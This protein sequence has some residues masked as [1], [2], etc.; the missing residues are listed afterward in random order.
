MKNKFIFLYSILA[1]LSFLVIVSGAPQIGISWISPTAD[2]YVNQSLFFNVTVNVS[3]H[4]E[5][6]DLINVSLDPIAS[7]TYNFTTCGATGRFGPTSANCTANYTGTTLAGLVTLANTSSINGTQN[8]TVPTSGTYSLEAWGAGGGNGTGTGGLGGYGAYIY[9]EFSLTAGTVL[10]I[11]V[12]QKGITDA[13]YGGGGGGASFV[14]DKTNNN[15]LVVAGG[16]GGGSIRAATY[17]RGRNASLTTT[18]INGSLDDTLEYNLGGINQNGGN[19]SSNSG[20]GGGGYLGNGT[21]VAV[22]SKGGTSYI[23]GGAGGST[24]STGSYGGFGGGGSGYGGGGGGGGYSGGGGGGYSSNGGGGG[25]GASYNNGT[26]QN[27]SAGAN[28][29]F[30]KVTISLLVSGKGGLVSNTTGATPFYTNGSNPYPVNLSNGSSQIITWWV[31]ASG[32]TL[33]SNYTFFVYANKTSNLTIGNKTS[34]INISIADITLPIINMTYPL[35]ISYQEELSIINYTYIDYTGGGSCWYTNNSGLTNS[36]TTSAGNNFSSVSISSGS[37]TFRVYCND[38]SNNINYS[39]VTFVENIPQI[40][41]SRVY[42]TNSINVPYGNFFNITVNVSCSV[43]DCDLINVSLDPKQEEIDLEIAGDIQ[44]ASAITLYDNK[45]FEYDIADGCS[46]ADGMAD[47]FDTGMALSVNTTAFSGIR[48]TTEDSGREAICTAQNISSMNVSRKV[49]VPNNLNWSRFLEI[50]HNP[51]AGTVCVDVKIA[52]N[53][54]SDGAD[55]LNTSDG[56]VT[57]ELSDNWMMWDDTS[58]TSGDDA[59]G[60]I[61]HQGT[62]SVVNISGLSPATASGGAKYFNWSNICVTAGST[63]ILMHFFTQMDTRRQSE[64]ESASIYSTFSDS[65]HTSGMSSNEVSQVVNWQLG[66]GGLVSNT[67][68]ATPFYT[69]GSNPYPVNLSAGSSQIITWWVNATGGAGNYTYFVYANKTSN[70]NISAITTQW[71]VSIDVNSSSS[72]STDTTYPVF[73]NFGDNNSTLFGQGIGKFNVSINTTNGTVLLEINGTNITARNLVSNVYNASYNFTLNGTYTYRWISWGNG[74]SRLMDSSTVQVFTVNA[75]DIVKPA[76]KFGSANT[77]SGNFSQSTITAQI[78]ASDTNLQRVVVYLY[79]S[80]G[81]ISSNT[82]NGSVSITY[83]SLA[84]GTYYLNASANDTYANINWTETRVIVLDRTPPNVSLVNPVNGFNSTNTLQN[85]SFNATDAY[86]TNCS[87]YMDSPTS[88]GNTLINSNL[89]TKNG[90]HTNLSASDLNNRTYLW[91]VNCSDAASNTNI[92]VYRNITIDRIAPNMTITSPKQN[93]VIGYNLYIYTDIVDSLSGVQSAKFSILNYSNVSQIIFNGSLNSSGNW[94]AIWNTSILGEIQ[95]NLTLKFDANDTLGNSY[96]TNYTIALD[97]VNPTIQIIVPDTSLKYYNSNFNITSIIQ[98]SNL[99]YSNYSLNGS[100]QSGIVHLSGSNYTWN[101]VIDIVSTSEGLNNISFYARDSAGN[102][103]TLSSIFGVDYTAPSITL[104]SPSAS[105]RT[106]ETDITFNW[107]VTDSVYSTLTCNM[108]VNSLIR[109]RDLSC[110]SG[111]GCTYTVG[112]LSWNNYVWNVTCYD[113]A[114]NIG[115]SSSRTVTTGWLDEDEDGVHNS[116]DR[117]RG[118]KTNV[119]NVGIDSLNL[120]VNSD[121]SITSFDNIQEVAFYSGTSKIIN[122]THNFSYAQLDLTKLKINKNTTYM[123]VNLSSQLQGSKTLYLN[124]ENFGDLCVK[125]AEL[126]DIS[127]IS[128][129]CTGDYENNF[130]TCIGNST[131]VTINSITCTDEGSQLRFDNLQYSGIVGRELASEES[132]SSSSSSSESTT[133]SE[134]SSSGKGRKYILERKENSHP[135]IKLEVVIEKDKSAYKKIFEDKNTGLE[136]IEIKAR[137][138]ITGDIY[139]INHNEKPDDCKI[140]YPKDYKFYKALRINSTFDNQNIE[141]ARLRLGVDKDWIYSNGVSQIK[142][143]KCNPYYKELNVNYIEETAD[144]GVY[145]LYT[146]GF[147]TLAILGTFEG[148]EGSAKTP[149]RIINVSLKYILWFALIVFIMVMSALAVIL[150]R[151]HHLT[152]IEK[153]KIKKFEFEMKFRYR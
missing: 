137:D 60:F 103:K 68:G 25:G 38:S 67:T 138:W 54:G 76:I 108:T 126:S 43:A 142:A 123:F 14:I 90:L 115:R 120:K 55:Y 88:F 34:N 61:Y 59:A 15:I 82:S 10:Q 57:W 70:A 5:N 118:T 125:D 40:S 32:T 95:G 13:V 42:P 17:G 127:Q 22:Q 48:S 79:N 102:S 113:G 136:E 28:N 46:L 144:N 145:D 31:N 139:I 151:K 92:S 149:N 8:W 21:N 107:T 51:T 117:V 141:E 47:V 81:Q 112:G 146:Q 3:C 84:E 122:F 96:S 110:S 39:Q 72:N 148:S 133:T 11:L 2:R 7:T 130:S 114:T 105:L 26:N 104:N 150:L 6:C 147:S 143:V 93:E 16:G 37:S 78:T 69:N 27:S 80:T 94:D 89:T 124:D 49:Y 29:G 24:T 132:N 101:A 12:G 134:D 100:S 87:L 45:S 19:S 77:N 109:G 74:S 44:S 152:F 129:T 52:S 98:D 75:T 106:N 121:E 20:A 140:D 66:K 135:Y 18:G 30:G 86:L 36:S 33:N 65:A 83:S 23:Y 1:I 111:V 131:G 63:K 85:F 97:N 71:N 56:D 116:V 62:S 9:G 128:S 153:I 99:N 50:L 64:L 91:F 119:T 35:N 4:A 58:I 53:M 73:Y 41:I